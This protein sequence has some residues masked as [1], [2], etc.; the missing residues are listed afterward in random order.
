[1]HNFLST[2]G[3]TT[4]FALT[5]LTFAATSFAAPDRTPPKVSLDVDARKRCDGARTRLAVVVSD[6]APT[7]TKVVVNGKRIE[8]TTRKRFTVRPKLGPK[9]HVIRV[10]AHDK[11][12]N[13]F[14]YTHRLQSCS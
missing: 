10:V 11:A 6:S 9:A 7:S 2:I 12:G 5:A 1:M 14:T 8:R 13:S 3:I 4:A